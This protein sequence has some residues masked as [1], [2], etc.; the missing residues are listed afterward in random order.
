MKYLNYWLLPILV[1]L[2]AT[3]SAENLEAQRTGS[4]R[5]HI[6]F[7]PKYRKKNA[8]ILFSRIDYYESKMV[9]HF[10]YVVESN[11]SIYFYG[12]QHPKAWVVQSN[13]TATRNNQNNIQKTGNV[14]NIRINDKLKASWLPSNQAIAYVPERGDIIS[15]EIHVEKMPH[16]IKVVSISGGDQAISKDPVFLCNDLMLKTKES[17]ALGKMKQMETL[18][19]NFYNEFNYIRYPDLKYLSSVENE[20][21]TKKDVKETKSPIKKSMEPVSYMPRML[22]SVSDLQCEE[23]VILRNVYFE[24]NTAEFEKRM[25]AI[26]TINIL[27]RYLKHYPDAKIILHG[28]TDV[29][30]DPYNNLVLSKERVIQVKRILTQKGLD[31]HRV[32]IMYHGGEQPLPN[33]EKG[34]ELN[35]RVEAEL[36]CE[37][38]AEEPN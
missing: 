1:V 3:G 17:S 24:E 30:G 9:L 35:R 19:S 23:R 36:I 18:V 22:N 21:L 10:R 31:K 27:H 13:S 11:D 33:C 29:Y 2:F 20:K 34:H 12:K 32:I 25:L 16:F 28:H 8:N 5:T 14:V 26:K 37:T 15:C 4:Q 38:T 7:L 6:D